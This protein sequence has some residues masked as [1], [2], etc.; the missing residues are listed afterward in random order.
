MRRLIFDRFGEPRDVLRLEEGER[1]VPGD[2]EV[3]VRVT[4]RSINPSDLMQIRGLYGILPRLPAVAGMEAVG[5]V[6]ATGP[7]VEGIAAGQRVM[8]FG[9]AGTWQEYVAVPAAAAV[10]LP[11]ALS[12]RVAAQAFVNPVTAWLMAVEELRLGPGDRLVVTAAGSAL[13]RILIQLSREVGFEVVGTVRRREQAGELL[14]LGAVAVVVEGEGDFA[15]ELRQACGGKGARAAVE[16]VGGETGAA[17]VRALA[18][19]GTM[20]VYGLMSGQPIALPVGETIFRGLTVRG[21]WL[22]HW[23]RSASAGQ[24]RDVLGKVFGLL[25]GGRIDLPVDA[26]YD[27]G[28]FRAAVEHAERPGRP[29]KVL[30]VG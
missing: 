8:P 15:G 13:G 4:H 2:G 12:D 3:L 20:L 21:F 14:D 16:A 7:G 25:A 30:L 17:A 22:A 1:P 5:R 28:Q 24:R 6:E 10:P 26:E 19:G 11:D 27:L 9:A 23:M 29:G 18:P